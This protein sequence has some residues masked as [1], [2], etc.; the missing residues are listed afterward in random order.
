MEEGQR[1]IAAGWF[2][3]GVALQRLA[4]HFR[5]ECGQHRGHAV[6]KDPLYRYTW[7]RIPHFYN[8]PYYVY[9]YATC[10]ASTA[11]WSTPR[12]VR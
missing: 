2:W 12:P 6:A 7:T 4:R 5:Q 1:F 9:Q 8:S 10:F 11:T 3:L